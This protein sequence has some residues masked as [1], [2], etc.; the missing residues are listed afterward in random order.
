MGCRGVY[1][2]WL[3]LTV[4][5][6]VALAQPSEELQVA[7][8][9]CA[10]REQWSVDKTFRWQAHCKVVLLQRRRTSERSSTPPQYIPVW[11]Y[12]A[13]LPVEYAKRPDVVRVRAVQIVPIITK[14]LSLDA[15]PT[16]LYQP[17]N[18]VAVLEENT[19]YFTEN[20]CLRIRR[21]DAPPSVP[22]PQQT[23]PVMV[24]SCPSNCRRYTDPLQFILMDG[25][26]HCVLAGDSVF[27]LHECTWQAEPHVRGV[28][29]IC[30]NAAG[31]TRLPH[32]V[33]ILLN[34][35]HG[36]AVEHIR[37]YTAGQP[38]LTCRVLSWK[39]MDGIWI[40]SKVH[41]RRMVGT[42]AVSDFQ[43]TLKEVVRTGELE[44]EVPQG[45]DVVDHRL[46]GRA[47]RVEPGNWMYDY[48][49]YRWQG[50]VPSEARLRALAFEQGKLPNVSGRRLSY[51]LLLPGILLIAIGVYLY[52]RLRYQA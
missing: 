4:G 44:I 34:R 33:E 22:L 40:P 11:R 28:L 32:R 41:V 25:E 10:Q 8:E 14:P 37:V 39:R 16:T 51:V 17:E 31:H 9:H 27:S 15:P 20:F 36:Y 2:W 23:L 24:W 50:A 21:V 35:E 1:L 5:G 38:S 13:D 46:L 18:S 6:T 45:T 47:A 30:N 19:S 43:L 49:Q 12:A 26:M 52:R 42:M 29:I 7:R 48:V 3:M